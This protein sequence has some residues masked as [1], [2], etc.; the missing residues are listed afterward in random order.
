MSAA[1]LSP[2]FSSS[3]R[4]NQSSF[5]VQINTC[6]AYAA[7]VPSKGFEWSMSRPSGI[8][9]QGH[10]GDGHVATVG[11]DGPWRDETY[12]GSGATRRRQGDRANGRRNI[13]CDGGGSNV[14]E[15]ILS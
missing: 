5:P 11:N 6:S 8:S 9:E 7:I 10:V 1:K 2:E 4:D 14:V 3:I 15:D 13:R 12:R